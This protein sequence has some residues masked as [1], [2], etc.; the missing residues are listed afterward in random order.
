MV[1]FLYAA[2]YLSILLFVLLSPLMILYR[3][4]I[5]FLAWFMWVGPTQEFLIV[6]NS[7]SKSNEYLAH[8][9]SLLNGR[10]IF[11]DYGQRQKWRW[12]S[13]S[14]QLF[15][16]FGPQPIPQRFITLYLPAV[17]VVRKFK[18]PKKFTFG[19]RSKRDKNLD[20][21]KCVLVSEP[22]NST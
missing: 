12:F 18:W 3:A 8:L 13:I 1:P 20:A 11:L 16:C 22:S 21:L 6:L 5:C 17:I 19:E 14:T 9:D 15:H 7:D 10:A 2:F 4:V